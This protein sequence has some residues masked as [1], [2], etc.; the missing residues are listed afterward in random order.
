MTADATGLSGGFKARAVEA[1][2]Q[3]APP[4][5]NASLRHRLVH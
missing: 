3:R 2:V 5:E 1:P 4:V